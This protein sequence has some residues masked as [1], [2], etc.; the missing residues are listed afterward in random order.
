M[1][2]FLAAF[3]AACRTEVRPAFETVLE[4]LQR[5]GGGGVIEEHPGGEARASSIHVCSS[6]CLWRETLWDSHAL[7]ASPT[8]NSRLTWNDGTSRS[9]RVTCGE[10]AEEGAVGAVSSWQVSDLTR[11]RIIGE[12]VAIA[13]R[14]AS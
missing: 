2:E 5:H 4:R 14:A 8:Y 7:I 9:Q 6:G 10:G 13:R 12:L 3:Q 1:Q 11:D